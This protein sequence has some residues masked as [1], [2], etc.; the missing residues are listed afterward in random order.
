MDAGDAVIEEEAARAQQPLHRAD[1]GVELRAADVLVHPDARDLV[2]RLLVELA[3]VEHAHLDAVAEPGGGDAL[4][5]ELRLR[6]RERHA[7]RAHAVVS[8]RVQD[9]RS[10]AAADVEHP[11][12]GLEAELAADQLELA[13][14]RAFERVRLA[15]EVRARV[16]EARPEQRARR[17]VFE[18]S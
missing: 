1:V 3:I 9:E 6:L 16:D 10:P 15:R 13:L 5:R 4:A 11:L 12:A 18:T 2:E 14:L 7:E 8:R 17:S